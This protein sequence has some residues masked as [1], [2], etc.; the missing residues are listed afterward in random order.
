MQARAVE[1]R[2]ES[3]ILDRVPF[4]VVIVI[5]FVKISRK[6]DPSNVW[7]LSLTPWHIFILPDAGVE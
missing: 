3:T 2:G 6:A 1:D 4:L 5:L 7:K